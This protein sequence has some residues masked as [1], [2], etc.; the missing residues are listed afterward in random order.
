M[1][2]LTR[3]D[4]P[5]TPQLYEAGL[6]YAADGEVA[7]HLVGTLQF[8]DDRLIV[9]IPNAF[10][11]GL[12]KQLGEH[13]IEPV[14]EG[15]RIEVMSPD[16]VQAIGGADKISERGK[17]YTYTLGRF[18]VTEPDLPGVSHLWFMR[19]HSPDLQTLRKSYGLSSLPSN[20]DLRICVA[21]RRRGVLGRNETSKETGGDAG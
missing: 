20:A 12:F 1:S 18:I 17:Q 10:V 14:K 3:M 2:I 21:I 4:N 11:N 5:V 15:G 6:K 13:G 9:A 16:E 8:S 19:V 7:Y